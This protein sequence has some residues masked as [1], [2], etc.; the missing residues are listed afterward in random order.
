[1]QCLFNTRCMGP[2]TLTCATAGR[3]KER[4]E[5]YNRMRSERSKALQK[6]HE[7]KGE[8]ASNKSFA[9][10]WQEREDKRLLET[11]HH[12]KARRGHRMLKRNEQKLA[13]ISDVLHGFHKGTF[14]GAT[15]G[16]RGKTVDAAPWT[17]TSIS[18]TSGLEFPPEVPFVNVE[19]IKML[20][21]GVLVRSGGGG[22]A[23]DCQP[24]SSST[25][26][27]WMR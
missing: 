15:P 23:D 5:A 14:H 27:I 11:M 7:E 1:M 10:R 6:Y 18:A 17:R 21:I 13:E 8:I 3:F 4:E 25:G 2:M 22:H 16:S 20:Y 24:H 12:V 26:R 19:K 9:E